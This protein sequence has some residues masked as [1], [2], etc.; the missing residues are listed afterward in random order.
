[1]SYNRKLI[2]AD[3]TVIFGNAF[4]S[5]TEVICEVVFQTAKT[6]YNDVLT[7]TDYYNQIVVMTHNDKNDD[8]I[9]QNDYDALNGAS[10]LIVNKF[11]DVLLNW[12]PSKSLNGLLK[13]KNIPGLYGVDADALATK[14]REDGVMYG[15]IVDVDMPDDLAMVK[16]TSAPHVTNH[17]KQVS[18]KKAYMVS[19]DNK[20]FRVA[21]VAFTAKK[22]IV[23]ELIARNCEV[24]VLPYNTSIDEIETYEPDGVVF[25][26]GPGDP[27]DLPELLPVIRELQTKYPL[28]GVCLG[29]QLFAIA[30]GAQTTKMKFGHRDDKMLVRDIATGKTL[31]TFQNH[32]FHVDVDSL[33]GTDLEVTQYAIE[34]GSIE[35]LKH[36]KYP[37][38][39]VQ[40]HPEAYPE[41]RDS[42]YLFDQFVEIMGTV[43]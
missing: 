6:G 41:P 43:K 10:A 36:K 24:V 21:V 28:F 33:E 39:S 1:M 18:P 29:H 27:L 30:N 38:F 32:G 7:D 22:G 25:S 14:I 31:K 5:D 26:S 37:A 11:S 12:H 16:L 17:V 13:E 35:G 3:G 23:N 4:G 40:Y 20:K 2:L 34:D 8:G 19:V 42:N 15:I 9:N